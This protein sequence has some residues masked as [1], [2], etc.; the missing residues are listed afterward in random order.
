MLRN[1][2]IHNFSNTHTHTHTHT[3]MYMCVCVYIYIYKVIIND[4]YTSKNL[5]QIYAVRNNDICRA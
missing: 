5:L 1:K 2:K 4:I 3:C